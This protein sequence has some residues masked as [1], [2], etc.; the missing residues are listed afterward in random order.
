MEKD[1]AGPRLTRLPEPLAPVLAKLWREESSDPTLTRFA[2]RLGSDEALRRAE[3]RMTDRSEPQAVRLSFISA[4]GQSPDAATRRQLLP[5][6]DE[7]GPS[8]EP[9]RMATLAALEHDA[10]ASIAKA[11]L[12]RYPSWSPALRARAITLLASRKASSAA[13][14]RSVGEGT[15]DAKEVSVDA[16]R[17]MLAHDDAQLA[18]AIETRWGKVRPATP[19]EKMSYVPVMGRMLNEGK[20]D[21]DS[22]HKLFVKHCAV[23][24]T[25][26]GEGNKVGPDLTSADRKNRD[27]LLLNILDPS[28]YVRPEYVAQTAVL[29]DGRVLTGLVVETTAQQ[30]TLVDAK[31][32]RLTLARSEID[33]LKPSAQSLMP[34]RLLETLAPQEVRDLFRYLQSAEPPSANLPAGS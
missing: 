27:A 10:D 26:Y 8:S 14:V 15:I 18:A 29:V 34:E 28:G 33:E 16:I 5:L 24:H 4:I 9:I 3:A 22:G 31:N 23:C 25:L 17:Q 13:L 12:A 21:L 32:Q 6:L 11:V 1:L 20:G 7:E 30:V 2:L 19:G